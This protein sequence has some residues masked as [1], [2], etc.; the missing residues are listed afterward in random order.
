MPKQTEI[1]KTETFARYYTCW[2]RYCREAIH[3][4]NGRF[5]QWPFKRHP[6]RT[7]SVNGAFFSVAGPTAYCQCQIGTSGAEIGG[8]SAVEKE[9]AA[10]ASRAQMPGR[11]TCAARPHINW[12]K[13]CLLAQ[14]IAFG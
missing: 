13:A 7:L 4:H 9:P 1:V 12:S 2:I 8:P 3:I 10:D 6:S 11:L 14:G 5:Q